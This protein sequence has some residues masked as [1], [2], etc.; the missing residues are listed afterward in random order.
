MQKE[1]SISLLDAKIIIGRKHMWVNVQK[2]IGFPDGWVGKESAYSTG[3]PGSIPGSEDPLEKGMATHSS[4]LAWRTP[5]TEEPGRLQSTEEQRVRHHWGTNTFTF[6]YLITSK[7]KPVSW[8]YRNLE[9]S[10]LIKH[11]KSSSILQQTSTGG[12]KRLV[13]R[14]IKSLSC[15]SVYN[16][17]PESNQEETSEKHKLAN[18]LEGKR[19]KKKT[20]S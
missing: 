12:S 2:G 13:L 18:I 4:I 8:Q 11:P 10:D 9:N 5:W 19:K 7:E 1:G 17:Y 15:N 6:W 20:G 16:V 3:D 14:T